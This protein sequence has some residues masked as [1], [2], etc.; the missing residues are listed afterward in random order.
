[1]GSLYYCTKCG[2][3]MEISDSNDPKDVV[4]VCCCQKH[5]K[6]PIPSKYIQYLYNGILPVF[7]EAL[8]DEFVR[9]VLVNNANY[10]ESLSW[11]NCKDKLLEQWS[12]D[13]QKIKATQQEQSY[14]PKCPTC[15][16]PNIEKI[17][18]TSKAIGG[19]LFG[20]FSS[21]VRKTMHCKNC[22]YKW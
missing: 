22:G 7:N 15:G 6:L 4:C 11:F 8:S 21:N 9:D 1:M 5:E 16:S 20:L 18:L 10:D 17:S 12:N 2:K 3:P 14:I 13:W 19:A